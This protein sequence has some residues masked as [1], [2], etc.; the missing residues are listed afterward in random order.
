MPER[1]PVEAKVAALRE[2]GA[3][4]GPAQPVD[5]IETHMSWVFLTGQFVYKL[6]KPARYDGLDCRR[7]EMRRFFCFEELRLNRRLAPSVYL[8]V[9]ALRQ[10]GQGRLRIGRDG[11]VVDWL[12]W[13]R[14]LPA[15][16]TL[17]RLIEAGS[18]TP[19]HMRRVAAH[20]AAFYR[21]LSPAM[22][23]H[24]RLMA[25]LRRDIDTFEGAL[26]KPAWALPADDVTAVCSRLRAALTDCREV[27]EARVRAGRV[28]E[29]HGDLRPEHVW[30]GEPLAIIDCL[31]FSA[32][33][34]TLDVADELG[35][36]ALECERLGAPQLGR[37]LFDAFAES[38][39]DVPDPALVDFYQAFRACVRANIAIRHLR[40]ACYR[41]D[42]KWPRRAREYLALAAQRMAPA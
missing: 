22:G 10:D 38:T 15:Q 33:L 19:A 6:K 37:A 5:V 28:V 18:A 2:P 4:P 13:M 20:L 27:L 3:Y 26:C 34:R 41:D 42:P 31:E 30:L 32:E 14:R 8:D 7:V 17:D 29:G 11:E 39:G 40:E 23:D 25:R 36:L 35:F 1:V 16:L 9:V 21:G 12:V 24:H